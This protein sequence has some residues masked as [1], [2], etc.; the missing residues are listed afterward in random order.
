MRG[1]VAAVQGE[2]TIAD[3]SLR[4][5]IATFEDEDRFQL[6]AVLAATLAA[7]SALR[8]DTAEADRWLARAGRHRTHRLFEPWTRLCRA[9]TIAAHGSTTD[10]VT[11]AQD[12]ADLARSHDL[13]VLEAVALYDTVRLSNGDRAKSLHARL[14]D[15]ATETNAPLIPLLADAA[16]ALAHADR[17]ALCLTADALAARGHHLL[18]CEAAFAAARVAATTTDRGAT[19]VAM[20]HA[21]ELRSRCP[22]ARTPLLSAD[23]VTNHL[24]RREREVVLLATRHTSRQIAQRLGLSVNTVNNY[25]ARCYTKLGVTG[26]TGLRTLLKN[27]PT[28]L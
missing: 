9:W 10:A 4:E 19:V 14:A 20:E 13:P 2:V 17:E 22:D 1:A 18:A 24:T 25:L 3:G 21:L 28:S 15:L 11:T 23:G 6:T 27:H 5:A 8:G 12:A 26:R 16:A 7:V